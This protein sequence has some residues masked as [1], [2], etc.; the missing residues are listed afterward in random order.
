[1]RE[2]LH[3]GEAVFE[4]FEELLILLSPRSAALDVSFV[5]DELLE[6]RVISRGREGVRREGH[7][8]LIVG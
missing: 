2:L 8:V 1:M 6:G 3:V 7:V 5:C 4:L